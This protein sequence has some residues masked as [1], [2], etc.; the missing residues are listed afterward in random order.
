[1]GVIGRMFFYK[2]L[3]TGD[4]FDG[5]LMSLLNVETLETFQKNFF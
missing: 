2:N 4:F 5:F 1:M 3:F